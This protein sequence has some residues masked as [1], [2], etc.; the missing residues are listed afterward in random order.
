[1]LVQ[2][3]RRSRI[4]TG[5]QAPGGPSTHEEEVEAPAPPPPPEEE[6]KDEPMSGS[7][8]P[9]LSGGRKSGTPQTRRRPKTRAG[10]PR[11]GPQTEKPVTTEGDPSDEGPPS[12][13]PMDTGFWSWV[14]K[15]LTPTWAQELDPSLDELEDDDEEGTENGEGMAGDEDDGP[16]SPAP[17]G[18]GNGRADPP[19]KKAPRESRESGRK[20]GARR[21]GK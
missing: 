11:S 1:M 2:E 16:A 21:P 8:G 17:A 19:G 14:G 20:S 6:G 12:W 13:R 10:G 18:R 5:A 15:K 4:T 7:K 3:L 9:S